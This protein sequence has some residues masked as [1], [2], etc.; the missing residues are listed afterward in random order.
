MPPPNPNFG[1]IESSTLQKWLNDTFSDN[2][3]NG[4]PLFAWMNKNGRKKLVDGGNY[5]VEP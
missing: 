4:L 5:L 1:Q 3:F 2:V